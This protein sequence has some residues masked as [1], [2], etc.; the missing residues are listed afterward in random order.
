MSENAFRDI[1]YHYAKANDP[2]L[3]GWNNWPHKQE[4]YKIYWA[5]KEALEKTA[6]FA[7]EAE[8]LEECEQ[9]KIINKLR[10]Q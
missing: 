3:T 5:V 9:E 2:Y 6:N 10:G 7:G 1:S 4:L 8:W